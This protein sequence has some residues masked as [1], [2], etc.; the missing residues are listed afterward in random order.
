M[1]PFT[2]LIPSIVLGFLV[3]RRSRQYVENL[4]YL[5]SNEVRPP[6]VIDWLPFVGNAFGMGSGDQFWRDAEYVLSSAVF[7]L[8]FPMS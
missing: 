3:L 1:L 4:S 6:R 8:P 7:F 2:L 5:W